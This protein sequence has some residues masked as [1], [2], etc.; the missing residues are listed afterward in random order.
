MLAMFAF[1]GSWTNFF[2]PFIVL[3]LSNP[4]LPVAVHLLQAL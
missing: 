4:P 3:G 1:V 2:W